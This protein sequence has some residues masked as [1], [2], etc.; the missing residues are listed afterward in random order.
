MFDV[1]GSGDVS[2]KELQIIMRQLGQNPTE[3][4]V[5]NMMK[6]GDTNNNKEIEFVEFCKLMHKTLNKDDKGEELEAVFNI[7]CKDKDYITYHSLK[8][9]FVELG[10]EVP[11]E[12]CKMLITMY[13]TNGDGKLDFPEFI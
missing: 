12:D 7:F 5:S 11:L 8:E 2:V 10:A 1:D 3:E 9:I 6:E 4:E 13:D